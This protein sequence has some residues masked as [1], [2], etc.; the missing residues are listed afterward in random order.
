MGI[1]G[2]RVAFPGSLG[3]TLAARLD[4]PDGEAR[5]YALFA[6]CFTCSKDLKAAGRIATALTDHGVAVLRF[7]FTGLGASGGE[8]ANTDF[9]SNLEDLRLAA[10]WLRRHHEAPQLLVGHSLGGSAAIAVAADI[11]E[12]R[13]VASIA[14]PATT[15]HLRGLVDEVLE[16]M[17]R[18]GAAPVTIAG[19]R[20]TIRRE[21]LDDLS[22]HAVERAAATMGAALLVLHSPVDNVVGVEHAARLF[23]AAR[24]PKSFV[25]VDGADHLLSDERDAT[26][27][28]DMIGTWARRYV[29]STDDTT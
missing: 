19:R 26:F 6:H 23:G 4:V 11:A 25:A 3:A 8:F 1:A 7:D 16:Q 13:A 5:A 17:G 24:H 20:F 29:G 10:A 14:A 12:V 18:D 9:S 27:A 21:F 15:E 2:R 22:N 28:A